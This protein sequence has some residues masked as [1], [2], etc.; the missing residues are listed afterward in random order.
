MKEMANLS[1]LLALFII[2]SGLIGCYNREEFKR[3]I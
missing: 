2:G 1:K 3:I